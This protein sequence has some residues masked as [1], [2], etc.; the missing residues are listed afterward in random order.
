MLKLRWLQHWVQTGDPIVE[1]EE[2]TMLTLAEIIQDLHALEIRLR[3]YERKYGITSADFYNLYQQGLLDDEGFE[4]STEFARWASAYALK[5][6][7]ESAFEAASH[8]FSEGIKQSAAP[9]LHLIPN[10]ALAQSYVA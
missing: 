9:S 5:L 2:L 8:R 3:A 4:Q 10:P 6:K 1:C 7:R